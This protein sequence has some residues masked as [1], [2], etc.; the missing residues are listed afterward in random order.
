MEITIT[1]RSVAGWK[2]SS[3]GRVEPIYET[4][5]VTIK[6]SGLID[7]YATQL[8]IGSYKPSGIERMKIDGE[9]KTKEG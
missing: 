1:T 8:M 6:P 4:S 9:E 2:A 7:L 3:D 5:T